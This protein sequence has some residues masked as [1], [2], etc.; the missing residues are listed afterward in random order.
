ML[1]VLVIVQSLAIVLLINCVVAARSTR[2]PE[3]SSLGGHL[4][5]AGKVFNSALGL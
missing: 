5:A 3:D 4:I 1:E 2:N